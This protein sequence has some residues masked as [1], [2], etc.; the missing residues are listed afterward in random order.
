MAV[1]GWF[2][3]IKSLVLSAREIFNFAIR[4]DQQGVYLFQNLSSSHKFTPIP[5]LENAPRIRNV[6]A[7]MITDGL[8]AE[9][10]AAKVIDSAEVV[11]AMKKVDLRIKAQVF[12]IFR[13]SDF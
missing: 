9:N 4:E 11:L 3:E 13:K 1:R 12:C 5:S 10:V 2:V 8:T 7:Q 6:T